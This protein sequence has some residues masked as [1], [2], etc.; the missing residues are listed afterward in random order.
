MVSPDKAMY[1]SSVFT[2]TR[3]THTR[4]H[5]HTHTHT[6]MHAHSHTHTHTHSHTM[7]EDSLLDISTEVLVAETQES[8]RALSRTI[9][10][11]LG[12]CKTKGTET[13]NLYPKTPQQIQQRVR[14]HKPLH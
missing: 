6:R 4:T 10:K 7:E 5:T 14:P 3:T 11:Q 9:I 12:I 1:G 13:S 2:H 8:L